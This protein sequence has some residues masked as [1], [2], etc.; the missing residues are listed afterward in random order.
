MPFNGSIGADLAGCD[1]GALNE[2]QKHQIIEAVDQYLVLRVRRQTI[3]NRQQLELNSIFGPIAPIPRVILGRQPWSNEIPELET[4]SNVL[5]DGK[6][7]GSLGAGELSWHSDV[8]YIDCPYGVCIL[9]AIE[10][11]PTGGNTSFINMY[12]VRDALSD[13]LLKTIRPLMVKQCGTLTRG[14]EKRVAPGHGKP[15]DIA[16][17]HPLIQK[18]PKSGREY[19]FLG[20]RRGSQILELPEPEGEKILNALWEQLD[21]SRAIWEHIWQPGDVIIWDNRYTMHRRQSFDP[22]AR[23]VLRRTSSVG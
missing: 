5:E 9:R 15:L 1:L 8:P 19:L 17:I 21:R 14:G 10:L 13:D 12:W 11:P 4:I 18:H 20:R 7:I 16:A 6:P 2:R 3:D 23:R 22:V